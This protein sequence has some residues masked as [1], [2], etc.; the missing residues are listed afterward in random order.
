MKKTLLTVISAVAL[1]AGLLTYFYQTAEKVPQDQGAPAP[2]SQAPAAAS[3]GPVVAS[4][5]MV[6]PEFSLADT[7]GAMRS[8]KD[9]DG[10]ALVVNFWATWCAPCRREMPL[11]TEMEAQ[12]SSEG[13][14]IIGVAVDFKEDV[15]D[16]L[17]NSPV[18]YPVLIGEQDAIDAAEGF[19]VEFMAM[20]FTAFTDHQGNILHVK[21]GELHRPEIELVFKTVAELRAGK[22]DLPMARRTIA[23]G[24]A[25][26]VEP[27]AAGQ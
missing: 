1:I 10:K 23:H 13:I 25:G 14:Q 2:M 8:I 22:M 20:P 16:Y 21:V 18:N 11:L 3:P 7:T 9:W 6:R 24:L 19:G 17:A 15:L 5:A 4:T 12:Y 27:V 26:V